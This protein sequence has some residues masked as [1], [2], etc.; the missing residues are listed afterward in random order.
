MFNRSSNHPDTHTETR[1][2]ASLARGPAW[3]AG[4][5]L[6]VFGLIMFFEAPGSPLSTSGFPDGTAIGTSWLGFEM[7]A[8]TAWLTTVAGVVV[9]LGASQHLAARAASV[10]AGLGLGAMSVIALIDGS[11]VLGLAAANGLTALGWGI[12]SA[13]LLITA[14]LPRIRHEQDQAFAERDQI[15]DRD[16]ARMAE[17]GG[18]QPRTTVPPR[19]HHPPMGVPSAADRDGGD[20]RDG[21]IRVPSD[22]LRRS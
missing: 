6:T 11:D 14:L 9:L 15:A 13:V 19:D 10:I 16:R 1:K 7:N 4:A 8:W 17:R 18:E 22:T 2:G 20:S 5:V 12:A 21:T 3:I